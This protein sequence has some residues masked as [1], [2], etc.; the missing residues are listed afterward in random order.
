V[1]EPNHAERER[2]IF[3]IGGHGVMLWRDAACSGL[4]YDASRNRSRRGCVM[5]DCGNRAKARRHYGHRKAPDRR[6]Q[7]RPV[8]AR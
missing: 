1:K 5:E 3:I 7:K 6:T 8:T 2:S 4:F